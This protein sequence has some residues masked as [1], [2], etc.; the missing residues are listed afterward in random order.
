MNDK[1]THLRD[2]NKEHDPCANHEINNSPSKFVAHDDNIF[3]YRLL[4][5][6]WIIKQILE[7]WK[8]SI[9]CPVNKKG[10]RSNY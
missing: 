8:V 3:F 5:N 7:D 1:Y 9:K 10:D 4:I 2:N 6:I